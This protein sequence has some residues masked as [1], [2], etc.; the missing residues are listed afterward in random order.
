MA[1]GIDPYISSVAEVIATALVLLLGLGVAHPAAASAPSAATAG[2]VDGEVRCGGVVATIVGTTGNDVIR[3]TGG[4]DVIAALGGDDVVRSGGGDDIV[5]GG[6][7][8]DLLVSGRGADVLRGGPQGDRI[9]GLSAQ[10][11][12]VIGGPGDD[13]LFLAIG[14]EPGYR[15]DGGRGSDIGELGRH[16]GAAEATAVVVDRGAERIDRGGVRTGAFSGVEQLGLDELLPYVY[17]GSRRADVVTVVDGALPFVARTYRGDDSVTSAEGDDD[18]D[19]GAGED[20]VDAGPGD[21]TCRNAERTRGCE[22][23]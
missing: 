3:G 21:D 2:S 20:R 5:C 14:D 16:E 22:S 1:S 10:P 4:P 12:Q 8:R 9:E 17:L 11:N 6:P 7:G 15:L 19:T 23:G 13:F 18:I